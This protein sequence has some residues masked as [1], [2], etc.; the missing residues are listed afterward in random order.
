MKSELEKLMSG[1]EYPVSVIFEKRR[2][3]N[4]KFNKNQF[5]LLEWCVVMHLNGNGE[6]FYHSY[7]SIADDTDISR[8][9]VQAA[10]K[11]LKAKGYISIRNLNMGNTNN[12]CTNIK[13]H[14]AS[15]VRDLDLIYD[16]DVCKF[17]YAKTKMYPSIEK[18]YKRLAEV[19]KEQKTDSIEKTEMKDIDWDKVNEELEAEREQ[20]IK[21]MI[22]S[23]EEE[24]ELLESPEVDCV[25]PSQEQVEEASAYCKE[26]ELYGQS[27][28]EAEGYFKAYAWFKTKF[29][30]LDEDT[31]CKSILNNNAFYLVFSKLT[32][33]EELKEI[34]SI[35]EKESQ[36]NTEFNKSEIYRSLS[37]WF[38][39]MKEIVKL[40]DKFEL[41]NSNS[42]SDYS[43]S[44]KQINYIQVLLEKRKV[45]KIQ[46]Q[47]F[48]QQ[49]Q[50]IKVNKNQVSGIIDE[51]KAVA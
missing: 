49:L 40:T 3:R 44:E 48:I 42:I 30:P 17:G 12:E 11:E 29:I 31:V 16:K 43:I 8:T 18:F 32:S 23:I 21:E 51:L 27:K 35:Y 4:K 2:T 9:T 10:L 47:Y 6:E 19:T 14:P 33:S 37:R 20:Q 15:I 1:Y 50:S 24:T 36:S 34:T 22:D 25:E 45:T 41:H 28:E 38:V 46:Q 39:S 26:R 7:Q 5:T 13:L